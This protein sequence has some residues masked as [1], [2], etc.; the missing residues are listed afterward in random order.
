MLQSIN[1]Y[2]YS[3]KKDFLNP[4]NGPGYIFNT[5]YSQNNVHESNQVL[6]IYIA[7]LSLSN[8]DLS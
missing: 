6:A 3:I 5:Y 1:L 7:F 2:T 4:G 8:V